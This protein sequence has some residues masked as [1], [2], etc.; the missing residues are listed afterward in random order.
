MHRG[1]QGHI[2]VHEGHI[3]MNRDMYGAHRG[4]TPIN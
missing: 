2:G 1:I 3:G 4:V